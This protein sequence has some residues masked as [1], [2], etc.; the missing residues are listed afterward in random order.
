MFRYFAMGLVEVAL[1]LSAFGL[2]RAM[3]TTTLSAQAQI[4]P[5][6]SLAARPLDAA[7][8]TGCGVTGDL[9]G[10]ANPADV[11]RSLCPAP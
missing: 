10:D 3:G 8:L 4:T 9:V 2:G 11:A 5:Q 7:P 6:T 1:L